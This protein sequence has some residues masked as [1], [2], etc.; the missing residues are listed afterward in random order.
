M[1]LFVTRFKK[2]INMA[3]RYPLRLFNGTSLRATVIESKIDK[4]AVVEHHAKVRYSRIEKYTYIS[5]NSSVVYAHIGKYCSVAAGVAIGGGSHDI[6][7]VST[8]PLF[9][10]GNNVFGKNFANIEFEFFKNTVIGNDVWIGNRAIILQGVTIGDGAVVGAGAV[11]TKDVEPYAVVAGNPARVIRKRFGDDETDKLL[12]IKWWNMNEK[13][14][15]ECG[16]AF[17][18]PDKF[19]K[20]RTL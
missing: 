11:V 3:I 8:S 18:S 6:S 10:K 4:T 1:K 14:L 15:K 2:F 5:A 9:F 16:E 13:E 20:V 17:A 7:A 19:L 12:K